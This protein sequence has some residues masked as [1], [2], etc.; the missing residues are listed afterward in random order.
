MDCELT[1]ILACIDHISNQMLSG[2]SY[3]AAAAT[4]ANPNPGARPTERIGNPSN[5]TR[6]YW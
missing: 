2:N 4:I 1:Q 3:A 6:A 5:E